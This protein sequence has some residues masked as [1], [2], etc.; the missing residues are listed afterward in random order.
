[1]LDVTAEGGKEEKQARAEKPQ[2]AEVAA[3]VG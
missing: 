1:M 3:V 2:L